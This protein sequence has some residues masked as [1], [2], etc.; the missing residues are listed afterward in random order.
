MAAADI[1]RRIA[2]AI[3]SAQTL[4][5]QARGLRLVAVAR[6]K[7]PAA[8]KAVLLRELLQGPR[9]VGEILGDGESLGVVGITQPVLDIPDLVA[10]ALQSDDVVDM[11]PDHAG[12]GTSAHEAKDNDLAAAHES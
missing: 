1:E 3:K 7:A 5:A 10:E 12:N 8:G 11:L 6:A 2:F 4:E 9:G